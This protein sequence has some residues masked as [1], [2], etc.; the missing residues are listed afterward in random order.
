LVDLD[1]K[2]V[3]NNII[4]NVENAILNQP[5]IVDHAICVLKRLFTIIRFTRE[6]IRILTTKT[7][8]WVSESRNGT[9]VLSRS[10]LVCESR[11]KGITI[12]ARTILYQIYK[13]NCENAE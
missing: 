8:A 9:N 3:E 2:Y 6:V 11:K 13:E 4:N 5:D 12:M 7:I 1:K 10:F